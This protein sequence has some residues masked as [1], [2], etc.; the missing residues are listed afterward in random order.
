R[1][2]FRGT[3][4]LAYA[5]EPGIGI[6]FTRYGIESGRVKRTELALTNQLCDAV[7]GRDVGIAAAKELGGGG[8]DD[9]RPGRIDG[10]HRWRRRKL[11]RGAELA[12]RRRCLSRRSR[13]RSWCRPRCAQ[14]VTPV[15]AW[16]R[17]GG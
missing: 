14:C 8:S 5:D 11:R 16:R 10:C 13:R 1:L 7:D 4:R 12:R 17:C 9:D 3:R 6:A 15:V 2:I